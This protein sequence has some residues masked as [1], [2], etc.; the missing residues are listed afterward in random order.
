M[1]KYSP[2]YR[3]RQSLN[4]Q[5]LAQDVQTNQSHIS[6]PSF[7]LNPNKESESKFTSANTRE[8]LDSRNS[9][10][11]AQHGEDE[12]RGRHSTSQ[13]KREFLRRLYSRDKSKENLQE[14]HTLEEEPSYKLE[15]QNT[16]LIRLQ[17]VPFNNYL[18]RQDN[19]LGE[20]QSI[21]NN[22]A[23]T[24]YSQHTTRPETKHLESYTKPKQRVQNYV[25]D[26]ENYQLQTNSQI[27]NPV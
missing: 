23:A 21:I 15:R 17:P 26:D 6:V 9:I 13:V 7:Y 8:E 2:L 12:G 22:S 10:I 5:K 18:E 1:L 14:H 3:E 16:S 20:L 25:E 24:R 4:F 19:I 27:Y 11:V